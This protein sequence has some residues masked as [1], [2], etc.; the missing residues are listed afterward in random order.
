M[1]SVVKGELGAHIVLVPGLGTTKAP[2]KTQ[3]EVPLL[4]CLPLV[5]KSLLHK[6]SGA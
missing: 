2:L 5:V 6:V 1:C 3:G 4:R